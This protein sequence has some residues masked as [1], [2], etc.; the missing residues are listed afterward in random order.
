MSKNENQIIFSIEYYIRLTKAVGS[1]IRQRSKE[2]DG[3]VILESL[4]YDKVIASIETGQDENGE[5]TDSIYRLDKDFVSEHV[6][7]DTDPEGEDYTPTPNTISLGCDNR[8]FKFTCFLGKY[9]YPGDGVRIL[10]G[11]RNLSLEDAKLHWANK[12]EV[13]PRILM[14]EQIAIHRGWLNP[15]NLN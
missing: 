15:E 10:A 3:V 9:T 8:G 5:D 14:A 1:L 4:V 7:L 12:P 13:L 6:F 11:C 2:T